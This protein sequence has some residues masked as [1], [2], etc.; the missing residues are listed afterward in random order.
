MIGDQKHYVN[1][2]EI[3]TGIVVQA[4]KCRSES[5]AVRVERGVQINLNH[6]KFFT[7]MITRTTP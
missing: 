4:I 5:A 3:E 1:V 6:D 7:E 2:I